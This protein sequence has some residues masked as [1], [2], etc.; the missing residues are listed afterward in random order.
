MIRNGYVDYLLNVPHH[1]SATDLSKV[2]DNQ[3]SHDQISR[4]LYSGH[5]DDKKLYL[6]G[7][8]FM[9]LLQSE[10]KKVIID[11]S[12]QPKPYSEINGMVAY[13]FDHSQHGYVKGI[14]F[15]SALW[16]DEKHSIPLSME[17]V[18]K[19]R[20]LRNSGLSLLERCTNTIR[21]K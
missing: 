3:F 2:L 11:D 1:V 14:N 9:K 19:E 16:A 6:T 4:M 18:K 12:I 15:I 13:H 20:E 17:V 7:K 21:H 10:G 8:R 5:T